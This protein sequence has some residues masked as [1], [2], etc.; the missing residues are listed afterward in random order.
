[1]AGGLGKRMNS[2]LPKV[3]HKLIGYPMIIHVIKS[4]LKLKPK[5]IVIIVGKYKTIIDNTIKVYLT[6]YEYSFIEYANQEEP[7][8][9]GNAVMSS[10]FN[11]SL[12]VEDRALILSGDVPLISI[13]T[14]NSLC[15]NNEDKMLITKLECPFG[16]GRIIF[17]KECDKVL[18]II[19]EK[20]STDEQKN[21]KYVNCGIYQISISNLLRFLPLIDNNNKSKEYYLTD[22]VKIMKNHNSPINFYELSPESHFEIKNVNTQKDLE[23]LNQEIIKKIKN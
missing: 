1:M 13:E 6:D 19:E 20:E 8:G 23:D 9:T 22:I 12:Y 3:L 10:L 2:E 21:I 11:L 15:N 16:C 5:K 7:L 14:L 18:D 4:S 17:N